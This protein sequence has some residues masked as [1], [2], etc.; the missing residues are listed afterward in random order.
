[1]LISLVM[2][3][4][5][6]FVFV[7][8]GRYCYCCIFLVFVTYSTCNITLL[9]F[10]LSLSLSPSF[11]L[12]LSSPSS[13]VHMSF[14]SYLSSIDPFLS[15]LTLLSL[16]ISPSFYSISLSHPLCTYLC[17]HFILF[18]L[19]VPSSLSPPP[20]PPRFPTKY[21][22]IPN[23]YYPNLIRSH[24][25]VFHHIWLYFL[26]RNSSR[27]EKRKHCCLTSYLRNA[28]KRFLQ[29]GRHRRLIIIS[30]DI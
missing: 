17:L 9:C 11:L 5:L 10:L 13:C 7:F 3:L 21:S 6:F 23:P 27:Q 24:V 16:S 15:P 19:T 8:S 2:L 29:K 28:N 1:M 30:K 26:L 20:N 25:I 4:L 22:P 18:S 14:S 12:L